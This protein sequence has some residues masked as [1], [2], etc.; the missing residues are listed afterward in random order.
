MPQIVWSTITWHQGRTISNQV[1][2]NLEVGRRIKVFCKEGS[3]KRKEKVEDGMRRESEKGKEKK[4]E[5]GEKRRRK[6][7]EKK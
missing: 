6:K 7:K 2:L 4:E 3:G 1:C 5:R